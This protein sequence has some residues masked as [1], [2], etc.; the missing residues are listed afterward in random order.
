MEPTTQWMRIGG[1]AVTD[2]RAAELAVKLRQEVLGWVG[3]RDVLLSPTVGV[4]PPRVGSFAGLA[5]DA[6][7]RAI[8]PIGAFTALFNVS[9]QPA[10]TVPAGFAENGLP[11]GA[12]L[13]GAV[14]SDADLLSLAA[15]LE[16]ALAVPATLPGPRAARRGSE[17]APARA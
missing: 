14:G 11:V 9:G 1:R 13:V 15:E 4:L 7:F 12:Q 2:A 3:S 16:E 5:G 6:L 8:L 17:A 10:I